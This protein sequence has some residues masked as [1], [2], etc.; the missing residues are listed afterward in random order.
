MLEQDSRSLKSIAVF[1]LGLQ[2][3]A[4]AWSP[5][6]TSPSVTDD[7]FLEYVYKQIR[8]MLIL[9]ANPVNRLVVATHDFGLHILVKACDEDESV[10]RFGGGLTGHHGRIHDLAFVGGGDR[11][12][13]H[14]A[15]VSGVFPMFLT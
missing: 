8:D 2:P 3:T 5:R 1:H 15:S 12:A 13:R 10:F 7:W 6:S 9:N 4:I 14:L 11:S